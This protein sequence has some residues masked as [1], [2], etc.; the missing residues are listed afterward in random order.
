MKNKRI[1]LLLVITLLIGLLGSACSTQKEAEEKE[2]QIYLFGEFEHSNP[3]MQDQIY[4]W[5]DYFYHEKGMRHYFC[6]D[7]YYGAEL[8]NLWMKADNDDILNEM[9]GD[10][11]GTQ[12]HS[13]V[14]LKFYKKIKENCP[15]TIFHGTDVDHQYYSTGE[16][17]LKYLED[18]GLKDSKQY[19]LTI[20]SINQGKEFYDIRD[21][22]NEYDGYEY[23]EN[24][25]VEN[26]LRELETVGEGESIFGS[27][28]AAHVEVDGY[29][30]YWDGENP[31]F[32]CMSVQ[33]RKD[34]GER[35]NIIMSYSYH[36][37][38]PPSKE[39]KEQASSN[40]K[41]Y[42]FGEYYHGNP[43]MQD[44]IYAWWDYFYHEKGMRHYFLE[45]S[46][47]EAEYL[48][49]WM[50][51]DNDEI[52]NQLYEDFE[53]TAMHSE[54]MTD[55]LKKIKENCPETVF[56]G[57]DVGHQ[58]W[59]MGKRYLAY[60]EDNDMK[61][62]EKYKIALEN[63]K[64]GEEYYKDFENYDDDDDGYRE[65]MMVQNFLRELGTLDENESVFG[66]YGGAHTEMD[67]WVYSCDGSCDC[68]T[69]QLRKHLHERLNVIQFYDKHKI[70]PVTIKDEK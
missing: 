2:Q 12:A 23:R 16:R 64:Q 35:L 8:L 25:M 26:F 66:S 43:V 61:D 17:Y 68:M 50:K 7:S 47:F 42:I 45:G 29:G 57:T 54:V 31:M 49:L 37:V 1:M 21:N 53:G 60:L 6:E 20:E 13:E 11:E 27:Y 63:F 34:L 14:F 69:F 15:E 22:K 5:W 33:L 59:N 58:F 10:L 44:Q 46:F 36:E 55:F 3:D 67:G 40:Q 24:K 41:I 52:L 30:W 48:N 38:L 51:A 19:E 4:A 56:H 18:N 70:V 65:K 39:E 9:Y 28:G 32:D 62:T